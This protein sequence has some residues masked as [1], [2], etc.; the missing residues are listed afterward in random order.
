MA[1]AKV[2]VETDLQ[3]WEGVLKAKGLDFDLF[4]YSHAYVDINYVDEDGAKQ[5]LEF[6]PD[7]SELKRD[8]YGAEVH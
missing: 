1:K 2:T 7:G 4:E 3:K 5:K 8:A 6:R